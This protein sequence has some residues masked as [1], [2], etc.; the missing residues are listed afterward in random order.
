MEIKAKNF[1]T[2]LYVDKSKK[3]NLDVT[4]TRTSIEDKDKAENPQFVDQEGDV[5]NYSIV[6][7]NKK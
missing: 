1:A 3:P 2:K 6:I 7:T 5:I 4:K